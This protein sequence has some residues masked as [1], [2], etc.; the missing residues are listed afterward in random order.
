MADSIDWHAE[1]L[2]WH[3]DDDD[4]WCSHLGLLLRE[5]D[6]CVV[7]LRLDSFLL[8][9]CSAHLLLHPLAL[10]SDA[11]GIDASRFLVGCSTELDSSENLSE[12][13]W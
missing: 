5:C 1:P 2:H 9:R 6:F 11:V 13:K 7:D 4:K 10:R 8:R 3:D 12:S